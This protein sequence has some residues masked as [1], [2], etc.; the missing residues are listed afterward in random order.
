MSFKGN[1]TP[2]HKAASFILNEFYGQNLDVNLGE[3]ITFKEN[4]T[5]RE[6]HYKLNIRNDF[7]KIA[8]HS[9]PKPLSPQEINEVINNLENPK[10]INKYLP[11][12][13][14]SFTGF[15]IG[16]FTDVTDLEVISKVKDS[17]IHVEE[18]KA[19][20]FIEFL[21]KQL[22]D[23]LNT[24]DIAVGFADLIYGSLYQNTV[25]SITGN[26]QIKDL[27]N[28]A[29]DKDNCN[30]YQQAICKKSPI[31]IED[32]SSLQNKSELESDLLK[33]GFNSV[34]LIPMIDAAGKIGN[35]IELGAKEKYAF[36][37]LTLHKIKTNH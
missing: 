13:A 17:T 36:S 7:I 32:L 20:T 37:N 11:A 26:S 29:F 2:V 1:A 25:L 30:I 4:K 12:D 22:K 6:R 5:G 23:F 18:I 33:N 28:A 15:G 24:N 35:I 3:I 27:V 21:E 34:I 8:A 31:I 9:K 19:E 10:V 16:T 14:F